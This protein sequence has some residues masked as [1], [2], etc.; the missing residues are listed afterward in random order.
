MFAYTNNG[1]DFRAVELEG[2]PALGEIWFPSAPATPEDLTKAFP[3]YTAAV[4]I[5]T[6]TAQIA[7]I[8]GQIDALDGGAQARCVRLGLLAVLPAGNEEL[9]R[10]QALEAQIVPLRAEIAPLAAQLAAAQVAL[11]AATAP[12]PST[13]A[14]S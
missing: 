10:L 3:G 6:L 12:A 11:L 13:P 5:H 2:T 1:L 7:D 14:A 8:Q 4:E 9:T